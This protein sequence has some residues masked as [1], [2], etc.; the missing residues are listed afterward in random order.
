M[1]QDST[2]PS[3]TTTQKNS[4]TNPAISHE[5]RQLSPKNLLP[6][7]CSVSET[8]RPISK[9][10]F[11]ESSTVIASQPDPPSTSV[12]Q[13]HYSQAPSGKKKTLGELAKEWNAN[14]VYNLCCSSYSVTSLLICTV[15]SKGSSWRLFLPH[16]S[17]RYHKPQRL[18]L[19]AQRYYRRKLNRN[20][21]TLAPTVYFYIFRVL[22]RKKIREQKLNNQLSQLLKMISPWYDI[23]LTIPLPRPFMA[24]QVMKTDSEIN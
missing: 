5:Y 4:E 2:P 10:E 15:L 12:N 22:S 14:Q 16:L 17:L 21:P 24:C 7:K 1:L 23:V 20:L 9:I 11:K 3:S 19:N 6:N 8:E 18:S 13:S